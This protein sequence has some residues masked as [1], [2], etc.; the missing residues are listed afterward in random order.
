MF[1][2]YLPAGPALLN[3]FPEIDKVVQFS[4]RSDI[5]LSYEDKMFQEDGVFFMDSTA[6]EVF[7]WKLV[8]GNPKTVLAAPTA[9]Y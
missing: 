3:D 2:G 4:G 7:S 6:F 5:L 9:S 1:G 8:K